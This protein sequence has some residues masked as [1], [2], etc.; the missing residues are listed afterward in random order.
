MNINIAYV[1]IF[2]KLDAL[3]RKKVESIFSFH[4]EDVF[5]IT[6][7]KG[8]TLIGTSQGFIKNGDIL[9][10]EDGNTRQFKV[11]GIEM[12]DFID[13]AKEFII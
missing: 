6:S 1:C 3:L 12:I 5:K 10:N 8:I 2:G 11:I 13:R 4:F 9:I 7:R